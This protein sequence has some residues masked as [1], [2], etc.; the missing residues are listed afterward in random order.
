MR[1][2]YTI[3]SLLYINAINLTKFCFS[4]EMLLSVDKC[5]HINAFISTL[6]R[7]KKKEKG[8]STTAA[9]LLEQEQKLF[10][11]QMH[12]G[13]TLFSSSKNKHIH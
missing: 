1:G 13:N 2:H 5:S 4:M 12:T 6:N 3:R 11:Y 9:I 7:G 10:M 8:N